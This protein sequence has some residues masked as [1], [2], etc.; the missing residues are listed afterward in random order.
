MLHPGSPAPEVAL[1]DQHG[2]PFR[3]SALRGKGPVVV[4]FYPKDETLVCTRQACGFRD[5]HSAFLGLGATVIGISADAPASHRAFAER[6]RLPFIL[7]SDPD[8][9]VFRSFGLKRFL[10]LKQRATFVLDDQ[11]II[12]AAISDRLNAAKHVRRALAALRDQGL[13][14]S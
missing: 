5:S 7:L 9:A 14:S 13:A 6:H 12:R 3:L 1:L 10:G 2:M 4:Y 8:D 11:G